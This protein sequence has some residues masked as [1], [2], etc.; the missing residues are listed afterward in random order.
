[1]TEKNIDELNDMNNSIHDTKY[2]ERYSTEFRIFVHRLRKENK[3]S[4]R[5]IIKIC[6]CEFGL[7]PSIGHIK[8][9]IM[10]GEVASKSRV[11]NQE[12]NEEK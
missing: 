3:L 9:L 6:Q 5:K 4:Y 2:V 7:S 12:N 10:D 11:K 1:M 8:Q